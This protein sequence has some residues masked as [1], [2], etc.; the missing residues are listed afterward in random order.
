MGLAALPFLLGSVG[1]VAATLAGL[2]APPTGMGEAPHRPC[3]G[4]VAVGTALPGET[5]AGVQPSGLA[6]L[7]RRVTGGVTLVVGVPTARLPPRGW[8]GVQPTPPPLVLGDGARAHDA[9]IL[10][11][12]GWGCDYDVKV[13]K[14][15][16][17]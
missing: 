11:V 3:D 14:W 12:N 15:Q 2:L 6:G 10:L 1:P 4:E 7:P 16:L 5:R 8:E 9:V 13:C 17:V